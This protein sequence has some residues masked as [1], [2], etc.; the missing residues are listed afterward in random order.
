MP[1][2]C[3]LR[4]SFWLSLRVNIKPEKLTQLFVFLKGSYCWTFYWTSTFIERSIIVR[5]KIEYLN[6]YISSF[7]QYQMPSY[8]IV[9]SVIKCRHSFLISPMASFRAVTLNLLSV[10]I[11]LSWVYQQ[12]H[13]KY[14]RNTVPNFVQNQSQFMSEKCP[15]ST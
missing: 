4:N 15:Y 14:S 11:V 7:D 5:L 1:C 10:R 9:F 3:S 13:W 8:F 6:L 12:K 2:W